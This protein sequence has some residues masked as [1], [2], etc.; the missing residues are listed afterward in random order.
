VPFL[1]K[2]D[3][4]QTG[5]EPLKSLIEETKLLESRDDILCANL[6]LG[7][8]WIDAPNTSASTVVSALDPEIAE[9]VAND[10]ALKLWR[11]RRDYKFLI[12]AEEPEE[13]VR[14]AVKGN[15]RRIFITDSGD[16]TTAG[17]EGDTTKILELFLAASPEKKVCVAGITDLE[18]VDSL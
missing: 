3:T 2:N 9:R 8:C 1:L 15:E 18:T 5:Y 11:T 6:F 14:R 17:A 7:H 12:E 13:C 10:L 4:L 16:N